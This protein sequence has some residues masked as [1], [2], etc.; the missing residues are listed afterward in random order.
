MRL[1]PGRLEYGS[2]ELVYDVEGVP[3][4]DSPMGAVFQVEDFAGLRCSAIVGEV[5]N[6]SI[7]SIASVGPLIASPAG[8]YKG[9]Y[10]AVTS[11]DN[12]FSVRV[13]IAENDRL[14][15]ADLQIRT[16]TGAVTI[17]WNGLV[18]WTMGYKGTGSNAFFLPAAGIWYGNDGDN[19]N[20]AQTGPRAAW[21]DE[22]V[23]YG[24]P[25]QRR[26]VWT[27]ADIS[28]KTVYVLT[29]MM[30]APNQRLTAIPANAIQT[31][32]FLRIEQVNAE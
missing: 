4:F 16:N 24:A 6:A 7:S 25:E 8:D 13:F 20:N 12:K 14:E 11:P 28:D 9:Y 18:S 29:F 22:D 15:E 31:K 5:Q 17:I 32:A 10:R 3:S 2:G 30:G 1:K 27:T 23:Y 21:G 19:G 26:Y